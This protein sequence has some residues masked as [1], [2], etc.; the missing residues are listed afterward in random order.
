M[1]QSRVY[2]YANLV[3]IYVNIA[4]TDVLVLKHQAISN[5]ST[6]LTVLY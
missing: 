4:T 6:D 3:I 5:R 2:M 1:G